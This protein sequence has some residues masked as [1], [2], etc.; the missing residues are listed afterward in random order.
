MSDTPFARGMFRLRL[1]TAD[2]CHVAL[3][4][5]MTMSIHKLTAGSGYDY[6]TRQVAAFDA[7]AKGHVGLASYYDERGES[8]GAWIGSGMVGIDGLQAGDPVTSEQRLA[9]F[10]AG[11]HPLAAHRL[12]QLSDANLSDD[13][14]RAATR[15]G[16]PFRVMHTTPNRFQVEVARRFAAV[17]GL[18]DLLAA[19]RRD[20]RAEVAREFF[21]AE[22]GWF[23]ADE[24]ELAATI[25]KLSRPPAQPIAGYDLTFSPGQVSVNVMGGSRSPHRSHDRTRPSRGGTR[26]PDLHREACLVHRG[27]APRCAA[28]ERPRSGCGSVHPSRQPLR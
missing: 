9:L 20:M 14:V 25:V 4:V 22:H 6:L 17:T 2:R 27:G 12:Q 10:G 16:A 24:R 23:P 8:P 13:Q 1:L 21:Q 15:L 11:M 28:G 19:D 5:A 18:G 7:T 26:R 3:R